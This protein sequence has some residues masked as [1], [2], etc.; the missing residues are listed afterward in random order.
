[1][2]LDR[3]RFL[4]VTAASLTGTLLAACDAN[5]EK[6]AKLLDF[7]ERKNEGLERGLFR[8]TSMD[9]VGESAK[10][11]GNAFPKYFISD[12]VPVWDGAQN[13]IWRLEVS[14]AVKTPLA[15][16]LD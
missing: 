8:H 12:N 3:R 13:G 14:G 10:I 9:S 16:T 4:T 6:A 5:P 7:A 11:A 15:L 1:M 2:S